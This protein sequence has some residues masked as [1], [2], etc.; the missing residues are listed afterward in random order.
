MQQ[1]WNLGGK[2]YRSFGSNARY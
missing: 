1:R 2:V